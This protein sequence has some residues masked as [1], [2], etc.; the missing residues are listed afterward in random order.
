ML[1]QSNPD[2]GLGTS[3]GVSGKHGPLQRPVLAQLNPGTNR[4]LSAHI[5]PTPNPYSTAPQYSFYVPAEANKRLM[6]ALKTAHQ[7]AEGASTSTASTHERPL[8]AGS[9]RPEN[10][11]RETHFDTREV[12]TSLG[13]TD[14]SDEP[15]PHVRPEARPAEQGWSKL[16]AATAAS[17]LGCSNAGIACAQ[18]TDNSTTTAPHC[19][20]ELG[21]AWTPA[22]RYHTCAFWV[23]NAR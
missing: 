19:A 22:L 7:D 8:V 3:P 1:P 12:G 20:A 16:L 2:A 6:M 11:Q 23:R 13:R 10:A 4:N 18:A 5:N 9:L 14:V 15:N 17:W 21:S